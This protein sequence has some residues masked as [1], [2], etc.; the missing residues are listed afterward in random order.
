MNKKEA[1]RLC[2]TSLG[3]GC[4]LALMLVIICLKFSSS[5]EDFKAQIPDVFFTMALCLVTV[6]PFFCISVMLLLFLDSETVQTKLH[7]VSARISAKI[8]ERNSGTIYPY[9]QNFLFEL[10]KRKKDM[11]CLPVGQDM[12]SLRFEG[13]NVRNGCVFYGFSMVTPEQPKH[14]TD[15]L[16]QLLQTFVNTE[17]NAYGIYGLSA[18]YCSPSAKCYSI[19]IDRVTYDED[20]HLLTAEVLYICTEKSAQYYS[21]AAERDKKHITAERVVYDDEV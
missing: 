3:L 14:D 18:V 17:L 7:L 4:V 1:K 6:I 5:T 9:L 19:Y 8:T 10:I 11:L 16:R 21:H 20:N 15:T 12:S 13:F 2:L